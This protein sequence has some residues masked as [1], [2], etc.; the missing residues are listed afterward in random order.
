MGMSMNCRSRLLKL[1]QGAPAYLTVA[2]LCFVGLMKTTSELDAQS[3][4]FL[5]VTFAISAC[6][7]LAWLF[8]VQ[9]IKWNVVDTAAVAM[10]A[11]Y[12]VSYFVNDSVAVSKLCETC[13]SAV[14]YLSLRVL[15]VSHRGLCKWLF[16]ALCVCGIIEA[17]TGLRQA[18]GIGQS[19]HSLFRVTG[20]FFNP[21]PYGG[22]LAV[23]LSI[24]LGY[25]TLAYRHAQKTI[26]RF[27]NIGNVRIS[28]IFRAVAFLAALCAVVAIAMILPSTMSRAAFVSTGVAIIAIVIS[29]SRI[30]VPIVDYMHKH[31]KRSVIIGVMSIMVLC[32]GAY[33]IYVLKKD[34]ADGRLL[35]WKMSA[36]MMVDNPVTGVGQGYWAGAFGD[37][38]AEYFRSG[39]RSET[40][41]DVAGCPEYGFNEYLQIGAE[42]GIPGLVLFVFL[43][44]AAL[45]TLF[46]ARSP[47][48]FGLIAF[49]VF[50]FFSYPFAVL[51]LNVLFVMLIAVAGQQQK[52][53]LLRPVTAIALAGCLG[54]AI[55]VAK[56][57]IAH[58][59]ATKDWQAKRHWYSA[60][61]YSYV[62]E[63]Y[64]ELLPLMN[65]NPRF[66]F[67]YG[68]S[69]NLE[70]HHTE[71]IDILTR[72]ARLSSDPM[73]HN[74][75][76]N[77]H[78]A[79]GE[80]EQAAEAYTRA[81]HVMPGRMYP[82]YLLAKMYSETGDTTQ[83]R[84]YARLVVDMTPKIAS[85]ATR[86]MQRE[87]KEL[88]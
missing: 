58:I 81:H 26:D 59:E 50:A 61:I 22:Y 20:T 41:V 88:L 3:L 60:G 14:A 68:R 28:D 82:L 83:A 40:E 51:P 69:L 38:Q 67:E 36:K 30:R 32:G 86:E 4:W 8:N 9:R 24:A 42:T 31:R 53:I 18:F 79:L 48:A 12:V 23:I 87:M 13:M 11:W 7:G 6:A 70:G 37:A 57:Y 84:H 25:L 39:Q 19:N 5:Y 1:L 45:L 10:F 55:F 43:V 85:P 63:D 65:D 54:A 78:K 76:G 64:P 66:L 2:V 47:F 73:I 29:N 17:I 62:L 21:G 44:A 74:V 77:N 49:L 35:M 71:S 46:R 27:K 72:A 56:P 15:L 34:S 52:G 80:Y 16:V 75:I 33:G